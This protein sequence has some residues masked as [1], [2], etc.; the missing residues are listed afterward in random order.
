[1]GQIYLR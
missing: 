1:M